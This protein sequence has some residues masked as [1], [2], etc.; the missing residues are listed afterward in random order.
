M[1]KSRGKKRET[2]PIAERDVLSNALTLSGGGHDLKRITN[3]VE[4]LEDRETLLK[5][6][7][8][9]GSGGS[10]NT[11]EMATGL[12]PGL[13]KQWLHIGKT[14]DPSSHFNIL[15]RYYLAASAEARLAAEASLLCKNPAQWLERCDPLKQLEEE[16][17]ES[18]TL[19][20]KARAK[21]STNDTITYKEFND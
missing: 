9:V 15:Y 8:I 5:I 17:Q 13:L 16:A 2:T 10:I 3:V 1:S 14:D 7:E 19:E 11:V 21:E 4:L 12:P 18:S 20:G 6:A